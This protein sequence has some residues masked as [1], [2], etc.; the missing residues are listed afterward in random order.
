MYS[1]VGQSSLGYGVGLRSCHFPWLEQNLYPEQ[2]GIDWFEVITENIMDNYGYARQF[3]LKIREYY[4]IALHGVSLSI[5]S[6]DPLNQ[7][8][9][10]KLKKLDQELKPD[11]ISDHLCWTGVHGINSHDLLPVP[12][13]QESL[14]HICNRLEQVQDYLARPIL[15]ENPSSYLSFT[16]N[17]YHEA[18]FLK[19][20]VKR[21]GCKLLID[22]NNIYVSSINIGFDPYEY[23]IKLPI[24]D[25]H[26]CHLAGPTHMGTHLIDTHDQPVPDEVWKLYQYLIRISEGHISTLLEWDANIPDFPDLVAELNLAKK[27]LAGQLPKR[28]QHPHPLTE[29][30]S[31]I[32]TPLAGSMTM[33]TFHNQADEVR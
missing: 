14:N 18:D 33:G 5:G 4:P 15:L 10:N 1:K 3:L 22:L 23:L 7:D 20:L 30:V 31:P 19:E 28:D 13:T 25:I 8:Y 21:T 26:Q 11:I 29:T 16:E 6:T 24:K 9:L 32:S 17:E 12:L 2:T 27:V